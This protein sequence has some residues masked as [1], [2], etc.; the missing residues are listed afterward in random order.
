M[1]LKLRLDAR[2]PYALQPSSIE[3]TLLICNLG[4]QPVRGPEPDAMCLETLD[5]R[6]V[7][8][9]YV[10]CGPPHGDPRQIEIQPQAFHSLIK[11]SSRASGSMRD[12]GLYRV[13]CGWQGA[14]SNVVEYRVLGERR[15]YV[16]SLRAGSARAVE[17]T[18]VNGGPAAIEWPKPC[19]EQ[20]LGL[21]A[22]DGERVEVEPA[23]EVTR[24][25]PGEQAVLRFDVPGAV[26]GVP[27]QG[28]FM[29]E[30]FVS[31]TVT[32]VL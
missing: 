17:V 19:T 4:A 28:R 32:L 23:D 7:P 13:R 3:F 26:R 31:D 2:T 25:G 11:I 21:W 9:P 16:A 12:V 29:R 15:A 1:S 10:P 20:D 30:P 22:A 5:E 6:G 18:L 27:L 24:I 14:I 8:L